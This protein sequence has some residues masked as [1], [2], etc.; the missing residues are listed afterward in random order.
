M[1]RLCNLMLA[2]M[3]IVTLGGCG[4]QAVSETIQ[5]DMQIEEGDN[6]VTEEISF[7]FET[8]TVLLNSGYEMPIY[9]IGT[10]LSI[11]PI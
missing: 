8:K 11:I 5:T 2:G 7:N 3:L 4:K 9:G 6:V 10:Y 1:K